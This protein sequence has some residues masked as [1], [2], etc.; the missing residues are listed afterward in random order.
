MASE[1]KKRKRASRAKAK[2]KQTRLQ[3]A[4]HTTFVPDTDF[5]FDIEPFGDVDLCSC[6]QTTYLNDRFPDASCVSVSMREGPGGFAI[7]A[8]IHHDEEPPC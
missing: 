8:V 4:G 2:A 5:S 3:R 6:C 1:T 7:T